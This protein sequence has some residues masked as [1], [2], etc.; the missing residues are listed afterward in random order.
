MAARLSNR[1]APAKAQPA[2]KPAPPSESDPRV[3]RLI[4]LCDARKDLECF[5]KTVEIFDAEADVMAD[6]EAVLRAWRAKRS[7]IDPEDH[8]LALPWPEWANF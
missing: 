7:A 1:P 4:A 8:R 5:A 6:V 3:R 2:L